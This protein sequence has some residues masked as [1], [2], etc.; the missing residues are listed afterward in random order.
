[1]NS[2]AIVIHTL[3]PSL[4]RNDL[5]SPIHSHIDY[6]ITKEGEIC[7]KNKEGSPPTD[8]PTIHVGFFCKARGGSL[9]EAQYQAGLNLLLEIAAHY[10]IP[11]T[12]NSIL[13]HHEMDTEHP[14]SCPG[15]FFP[16]ARLMMDLQ[17]PYP[18]ISIY[19]EGSPIVIG[20]LR[21]GTTYA[22]I[23]KV[24]EALGYTVRCDSIQNR[25]EL[26]RK[27]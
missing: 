16:W 11:L 2:P 10:N 4:D 26:E 17:S 19:K 9:T 1:M 20:Y 13:N 7:K 6:H 8:C 3:V 21:M 27:L 25:I 14:H 18:L 23:R 5:A 24:A 22:P 12:R 15:P